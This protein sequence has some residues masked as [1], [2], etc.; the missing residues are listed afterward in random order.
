M[1]Y[2]EDASYAPMKRC[3]PNTRDDTLTEIIDWIVNPNSQQHVLLLT[4]VAGAGK[5]SIAHTIAT[6]FHDLQRLGSCFCFDR[7]YQND[8]TPDIVFSNIARDLADLDENF[9]RLLCQQAM[10]KAI[11]TTTD[12]KAQFNDFIL[13]P[14][15]NVR[16]V[17]PVLILIDALDECKTGPSFERL[18]SILANK[19]QDLPTNFRIIL[20]SRPESYILP[21]LLQSANIIHKRVYSSTNDVLKFIKVELQGNIN[22][23]Q[24][25]DEQCTRLAE[26]SQGLFQWAFVVC[27]M[28]KGG[29]QGGVT[30]QDLYDD[31][32]GSVKDNAGN[33]NLLDTLYTTILSQSFNTTKSR[34][35]E[36]FRKVMGRV[37]TVYQP[38]SKVSL[39]YL[40]AAINGP[41][42]VN[43]IQAVINYM[44][45]LLSGVHDSSVIKPLH[46]SF[47][48]YLTDA[49]RS[50][51]FHVDISTQ[52]FDL[53]SGTLKIME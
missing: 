2:A 17:G 44:G 6:R 10:K 16:L 34:V 51:E 31:L 11:Q 8:R 5:S 52:H 27:A 21:P 22:P 40:E 30:S 39:E 28:L 43:V 13:K 42:S 25:S 50:K 15:K 47:H 45:A 14:M 53:A 32:M 46:S 26:Y 9:K 33:G 36:R 38:L 48:D 24:F 1:R 29:L 49:T 18:L 23:L 37:L 19:M 4:G 12:L 41:Q 20:T 7:A 35:M 3:I